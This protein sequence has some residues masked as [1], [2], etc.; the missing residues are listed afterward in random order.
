ME[1]FRCTRL[2]LCNYLMDKGFFPYKTELDPKNPKYRI[3]LFE[4]TPPL[5]A[6]VTRYLIV[7]CFTAR[8]RENRT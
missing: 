8:E 6:A 3:Y 7:D 5:T 1:T 4:E 2:R